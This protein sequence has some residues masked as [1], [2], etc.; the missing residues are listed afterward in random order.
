MIYLGKL[1][2]VC[3]QLGI[4][5]NKVAIVE[6]VAGEFIKCHILEQMVYLVLLCFL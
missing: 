6:T 5:R 4:S 3:Q 1:V 2:L